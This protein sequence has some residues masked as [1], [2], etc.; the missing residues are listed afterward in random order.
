M[1]GPAER[2]MKLVGVRRV[3]GVTFEGLK[4][5]LHKLG[6]PAAGFISAKELCDYVGTKDYQDG[7]IAALTEL[8][9]D[10]DEVDISNKSDLT[11]GGPKIIRRPTI[12]MFAGTTPDWLPQDALGGG[13]MGRFLIACEMGRKRDLVANPGEYESLTQKREVLTAKAAFVSQLTAVRERYAGGRAYRFT[14]DLEGKHFF[15][16]W[17]HNR[18][19][20][21]PP[22]LRAYANRVGNLMRKVAMLTAVSRGKDYISVEDYQFADQLIRHLAVNLEQG[23]VPSQKEV[24]VAREIMDQL[25]GHATE[26]ELLGMFAAKHGTLWVRRGIKFLIETGKVRVERGRVV[27]K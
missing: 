14:E 6:D 25:E 11:T 7:M 4:H 20:Y 17:Y 5:S 8:L 1:I 19:N 2:V 10:E 13:F 3:P 23:V 27:K 16:N 18:Y 15:T 12:S 21:F 26:G 24:A 9:S 22:S